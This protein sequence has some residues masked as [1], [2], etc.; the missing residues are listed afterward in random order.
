MKIPAILYVEDEPKVAASVKQGLEENGFEVDLAPDGAVGSFLAGSKK[1]DL[2]LL[3][4]NLPHV[5]GYE[6]C[7]NVRV[8]DP[9]VPIIMLTAMQSIDNKISGFD[10][11]A[12]DY[13]VKPFEFRELLARVKVFL[14]RST[15]GS[16]DPIDD[17]ILRIAD[18]ELNTDDKTVT[19]QGQPISL[20][21]K[22]F[23][24]LEYL[25]RRKGRVTSRAEIS[26][27]VWDLNFDTGTN[28]V[29]VYINFLRKKIDKSFEVKLI[30]TKPGMGY[31]L[32]EL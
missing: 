18:L 26:E 20:T 8:K 31:F 16:G 12:D 30:H 22:E 15:A 10:A 19:R 7:R 17:V 28:V 5:S 4:V 29:D 25:L 9:S 24:L 13:I 1:Y 27:N 23:A 2:I 32:K 14:K 21:A 3:D 11:G 6:V